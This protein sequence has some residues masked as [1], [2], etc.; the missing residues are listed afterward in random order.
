METNSPG[1]I[2]LRRHH[3]PCKNR[4]VICYSI[5]NSKVGP[6]KGGKGGGKVIGIAI[7]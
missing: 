7:A 2:G 6:L 1:L 5:S 4:D 3:F